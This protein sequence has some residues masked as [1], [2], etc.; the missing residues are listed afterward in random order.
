MRLPSILEAACALAHA[1]LL[2]GCDVPP[3]ARQVVWSPAALTAA[4]DA[5]SP[6]DAAT[7]MGLDE[8]TYRIPTTEGSKLSKLRS[9]DGLRIWSFYIAKNDQADGVELTL[10]PLSSGVAVSVEFGDAHNT[11]PALP[12]DASP[13]GTG[14]I[15]IED[16]ECE[17]AALSEDSLRQVAGTVV[18]ADRPLRIWRRV[19][20]GLDFASC[21]RSADH[22]N[23]HFGLGCTVGTKKPFGSVAYAIVT[24][25]MEDCLAI[26]EQ[27]FSLDFEVTQIV[28][29]ARIEGD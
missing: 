10:R 14:E 23:S 2:N 12:D 21:N 24:D 29:S 16:F 5:A 27:I 20:G 3:D 9:D 13:L 1:S 18:S 22:P 28:N 25:S 17:P 7:V 8:R 4:I 19:E 11:P 15:Y 6:A 26:K